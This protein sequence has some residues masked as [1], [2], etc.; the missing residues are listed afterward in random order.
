MRGQANGLGGEFSRVHELCP[1][2]Q[3]TISSLA[4]RGGGLEKGYGE[5]VIFVYHP[6]TFP[7]AST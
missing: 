2:M 3:L 4:H 1:F 7:C 6:L 5:F